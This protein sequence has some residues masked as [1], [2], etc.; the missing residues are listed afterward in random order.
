[1]HG[2]RMVLE[3]S[4]RNGKQNIWI[5]TTDYKV[6]KFNRQTSKKR[7]YSIEDFKTDSPVQFEEFKNYISLP[8]IYTSPL[9]GSFLVLPTV[10]GLQLLKYDAV[11]DY[12][13]STS[14]QFPKDWSIVKIFQDQLG[15]LCLLF[16]D[17]SDLYHA[18]LE[19]KTG[20]WFDYS[21][22]IA[23][24]RKIINLASNNFREQVFMCTDKGLVTARVLTQDLIQ[25]TLTD[26]WIS[27][28][29]QLP[30]H[31]VLI[32]TVRNGWFVYDQKTGTPLTFQGPDCGV[33]PP[34]FGEGM[35]QQIIPDNKGNIWFVS[36]ENLVR[37]HPLSQECQ[38]YPFHSGSSFF[39][40]VREDLAL[41]SYYPNKIGFLDLNTNEEVFFGA[42]V[43][44][45]IDGF[46]RD[47]HVD[48][49]GLIW[50]LTND[51][52]WRINID[53]EKTEKW[54][55]EQGFSDFRFTTI[56]ED[57]KGRIWLGTLLGG[58]NLYDP[59]T[60]EISVID[61]GKGLSSN[62]VMSI[63][64]DNEG[65][66]WV[67]TEYGINLVSKYG[68]VLYSLRKE[69]GLS[70]DIFERFDPF[71]DEDGKLWFG[72]RKGA[73]I[74]DP[75]ALKNELQS[76]KAVKIYLTEVSYYDAGSETEVVRNRGLDN[77]GVL[78][79]APEHPHLH[80]KFGLSSYVEPQDNRYAYRIEGK[81]KDWR[82]LSTQPELNISRLPAGKYR[83][84]IKGADFRNN[85]TAD[86][87]A[88]NIHA[89]EFFYKQAWFYLLLALPF[90][91]F[92]LLWARNK[93]QEASRLESEVQLRTRQIREDKKLIEQQADELKQLDELKSRFFT[94][95]SHELRTPV[96]LIKA[97][98]E[99]LLQTKGYTS[100]EAMKKSL[101]RVVNNAGKLSRLIEE[102]LDL[103][104]LEARK[105]KLK[106]EPT[107]LAAFCRQLFASYESGVQLKSIEYRLENELRED[108]FYLIDR[109][110]FEKI[111][112][113]FLSN[114]LKFTPENGSI[115]MRAKEEGE[116]IIIEVADS[117]RGIPKEDLPHVFDRYFQT[118]KEEIGTE[119]GTGIGLAL[120][121]EMAQL[122]NGIL[123]VN[124]TWGE[125]ATFALTI[126]AKPVEA[127]DAIQPI[128]LKNIATNTAPAKVKAPEKPAGGDHPKILIVEDNA[129]LQQLLLDLLSEVYH[130]QV[131]NHGAEAW[132]WLESNDPKVQGIK[133]IISDV[134]MPEMDGYTLLE[135]IKADAYWSKTPVIMLTARSAEED[136]LQALRMGVD[137]YLLKPFSPDE[138]K[139]RIQNLVQNFLA[140]QIPAEQEPK[141]NTPPDFSFQLTET[142][143]DQQWLQEI[144]EATKNAL[145]K[146]IKLNTLVLA[147]Q[148]FLSERQFARRLKKLTGLTP[149]AYI[150]EAR[151]QL[152]RQLL[153]R[154]TYT[155]VNEVAQA[156]GYSSGSYLSKVFHERFGK[157]PGEYFQ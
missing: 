154:Q 139:A 75:I 117:G 35:E 51:G 24:Q 145:E 146:G 97:P 21:A 126:P 147:E 2:S 1:P 149:N 7:V 82:Y 60:G 135:K 128:T 137:D 74:I 118:R 42:G 70:Y 17:P 76:E 148:V 120:S 77:L 125:G 16:R 88:I 33:A 85:W 133:L 22:I 144:E 54:G 58:L 84:L 116:R 106:E 59:V 57:Q 78:E 12:F 108:D 92:G 109:N 95:I 86:P 52:L 131:A 38:S 100:A 119:G 14:D 93:Q 141:H 79:I 130:C 155:T 64:E 152:A 127:N 81:D 115:K 25:Q 66:I 157:K 48:Q 3:H 124:S 20:E 39:A 156:A 30:D 18:V 129:D 53:T 142:S 140:R 19:T 99:H 44:Q 28:M 151:L 90:I 80:L 138:L 32:N 134:M 62:T 55:T 41:I 10:Q 6:V 89:R 73:S 63:I 61:E 153:E 4:L 49:N 98:L 96:T 136:K 114:A 113:N 50:I 23:G 11:Q 123:S 91:A 68:E 9:G 5:G 110:R 94:N 37:Y 112:N 40:F 132:Q 34:P 87:I 102:L 8:R 69:D 121:R 56:W 36:K 13:V 45:T 67:G 29:V 122:M 47:M 46:I 15:Q 111:V 43:P 107:P 105:A 150:Q 83:L 103:S 143:A 72:S 27:S 101:Q 31:R 104:K 65:D 26:E 71:K